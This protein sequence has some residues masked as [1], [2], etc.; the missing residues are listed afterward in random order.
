LGFIGIVKGER[1]REEAE[2]L[3]SWEAEKRRRKE[4]N[5]I[6]GNRWRKNCK[7]GNIRS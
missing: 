2:K 6:G 3:R 4:K 7:Y 5:F 1:G